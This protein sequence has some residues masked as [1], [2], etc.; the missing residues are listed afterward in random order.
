MEKK[1]YLIAGVLAV[2]AIPIILLF[3]GDITG[4]DL[5]RVGSRFRFMRRSRDKDGKICPREGCT[6]PI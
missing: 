5:V 2:L 3:L 1:V 4:F 6:R